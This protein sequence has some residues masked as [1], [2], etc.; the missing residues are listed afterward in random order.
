MVAIIREKWAPD[1]DAMATPFSA[2]CA[3]YATADDDILQL[4]LS[5][6]CL[7]DSFT[8]FVN[9]A[10]AEPDKKGGADGIYV[11]L[12]KLI[13]G[14][15]RARGCTLVALLPCLSHTRWFEELVGTS[16]EVHFVRG[17]LVF[18]NVFSDLKP[19]NARR[20]TLV[21]RSVENA[22][23]GLVSHFLFGATWARKL[24]SQP[25]F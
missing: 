3:A 18:P 4:R 10:Y 16:H 1:F 5:P 7:G 14:D 13:E 15:V 22:L 19:D 21:P 24:A 11:F 12:S 8:I 23:Q 6:R 2:I 25:A 20:A 17:P 9:P